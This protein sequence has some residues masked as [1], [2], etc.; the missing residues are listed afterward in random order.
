VRTVEAMA[1]VFGAVSRISFF[2]GF[3]GYAFIG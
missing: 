1:L 2:N 3:S